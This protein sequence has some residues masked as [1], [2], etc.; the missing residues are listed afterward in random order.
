MGWWI[1]FTE[2]HPEIVVMGTNTSDPL[3]LFSYSVWAKTRSQKDGSFSSTSWERALFGRNRV[4]NGGITTAP[5]TS[6]WFF[7]SDRVGGT[8]AGSVWWTCQCWGTHGCCLIT[9]GCLFFLPHIHHM[10]SRLRHEHIL[11]ITHSGT[12]LHPTPAC[13]RTLC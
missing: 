12:F 10:D 2:A 9:T 7:F 1:T 5:G 3:F 6:P 13:P 8:G 4:S 11:Q